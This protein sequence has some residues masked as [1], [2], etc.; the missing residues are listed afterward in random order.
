M[1]APNVEDIDTAAVWWNVA[2]IPSSS[3]VVLTITSF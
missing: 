3:F 2:R 1:V